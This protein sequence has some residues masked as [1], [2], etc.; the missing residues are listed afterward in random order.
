YEDAAGGGRDPHHVP[1][2]VRPLPADLRDR[3]AC[4][5]DAV[6]RTREVAGITAQIRRCGL[7]VAER[8]EVTAAWIV[9][10]RRE[11]RTVG[12]EVRLVAA[13]VLRA[14]HVLHPEEALAVQ[15]R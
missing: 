13:V 7:G 14:P 8:H 3:A 4:A 2:G 6:V 10:E 11:L 1:R 15:R 12:F 9:G 5:I